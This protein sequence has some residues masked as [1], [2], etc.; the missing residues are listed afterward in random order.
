MG[1]VSSDQSNFVILPTL[2]AV[3][4]RAA[5]CRA[6]KCLPALIRGG[7]SDPVSAESAKGCDASPQ[8]VERFQ[9]NVLTVYDTHGHCPDRRPNYPPPHKSQRWHNLPLCAREVSMPF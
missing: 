8:P 3:T 6:T 9:N 2:G 1:C 5:C 7:G 4:L